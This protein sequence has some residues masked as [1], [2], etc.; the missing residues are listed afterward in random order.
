[1]RR[2][3]GA[4]V[5]LAVLLAGAVAT[6]LTFPGAAGRAVAVPQQRPVPGDCVRTR[7]GWL[8]VVDCAGPH[9][10]EVVTVDDAPG[11]TAAFTQC[12][13]D[14]ADYAGE[15]PAAPAA[16]TWLPPRLLLVPIVFPRDGDPPVS[17]RACLVQSAVAPALPFVGRLAG[18]G[19]TTGAVP[20]ALSFCFTTVG[21]PVWSPVVCTAPHLGEVIARRTVQ[22]P[23]A[24]TSFDIEHDPTL[25][26][27]CRDRVA[28]AT[29]LPDPTAGGKL[30]IAL[31][32]VAADTGDPAGP[33]TVAHEIDC[34][35]SATGSDRLT[36]TLLGIGTRALPLG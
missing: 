23:A 22:A 34:T 17:W 33:R 14:L 15:D 18:V 4:V 30:L 16:D 6:R 9:T 28:A 25:L 29:G 11:P 35:V 2:L 8:F 1:V 27:G 3:L 32:D 5:V 31:D 13:A 36:A 20:P 10:A 12:R 7:P 26:A 24:R 19:T 21:N